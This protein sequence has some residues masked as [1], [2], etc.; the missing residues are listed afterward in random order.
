ML[1]RIARSQRGAFMVFFAILVPFFLGMI[2]FAVDAGFVYMQKAKMQDIAD[3]AALA[4]AARLNDSED[5]EGH[6]TSAVRAYADANGMKTSA[7][8]VLNLNQEGSMSPSKNNFQIAHGILSSVMDKDN[9]QRDH[10]RVVIAKRVPTFFIGILLPEEKEGVLVKAA[11]EAEY[12]EGEEAPV[13]SG[14]VPALMIEEVSADDFQHYKSAD[15]IVLNN[16]FAL[17]IYIRSGN[18]YA[19]KLPG[20][21]SLYVQNVSDST[22]S[23]DAAQ[24]KLVW[25]PPINNRNVFYACGQYP[26]YG[27]EEYRKAADE[28]RKKADDVF[29]NTKERLKNEADAEFAKVDDYYKKGVEIEG[30]KYRY[31]GLNSSWGVTSNIKPEDKEIELYVDATYLDRI[32]GNSSWIMSSLAIIMDGSLKNVKKINTLLLNKTGMIATTGVTYGNIYYKGQLSISGNNNHFIGSIYDVY[33]SSQLY[34]GGENNHYEIKNGDCLYAKN[35]YLGMWRPVK[36][37]V[38]NDGN[39]YD[40]INEKWENNG[41]SYEIDYEGGRFSY[42]N[43][44]PNWHIYFGG[45]SSGSSSSGSSGSD[46]G[47]SAHVRLVK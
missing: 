29:K 11:A 34:I 15:N 10:V 37:N 14:D 21:G 47:T 40:A 45:S 5:R 24:K 6:V 38:R 19:T 43:N 28:I 23:Y 9:V 8:N 39:Y 36:L 7:T 13:V 42:A 31:I 4:G 18:I 3:A 16:N 35:I 27:P 26:Y 17:P 46:S 20:T 44:D 2:G 33:N 30:K 22:A 41:E 1:G 32:W 25:N 12:V